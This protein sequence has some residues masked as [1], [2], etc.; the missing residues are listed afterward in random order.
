VLRQIRPIP[1]LQ[2]SKL[3]Q[4]TCEAQLLGLGDAGVLCTS[5]FDRPILQYFDAVSA[6]LVFADADIRQSPVS[7]ATISGF[8]LDW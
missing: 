6:P 4:Q 2:I 7:S 1:I 3:R 5:L 8:L